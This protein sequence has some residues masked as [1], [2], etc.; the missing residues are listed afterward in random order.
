MIRN[1]DN[2]EY[3]ILP[4]LIS[5]LSEPR[6]QNEFCKN[7]IANLFEKGESDSHAQTSLHTIVRQELYIF[8]KFLYAIRENLTNDQITQNVEQ[9]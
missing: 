3:S 2:P 4:F 7:L 1:E 9:D 6:G 5:P 8:S